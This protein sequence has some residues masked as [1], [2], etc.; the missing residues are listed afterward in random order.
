MDK[1][2]ELLQ[3]MEAAY[4]AA[5]GHAAGDV[6]DTDLRLRVLA[7]ELYRL[8]AKLEW[9]EREAFP[10]TAAGE[11]LDLHGEQRGIA[12]NPARHAVGTITFTRYLPLNADLVIPA[13]TLCATSG[14]NPVE[15]ETTEEGVL[16]KGEL[17][18][19]V[20]ARAVTGGPAGNCAAGY[21]NTITSALEGINYCTNKVPFTGGKNAEED[22]DYRRRIL[23]A[24]KHPENGVNTAYYE[25]TALRHAGVTSA[26]AVA[27]E[28]GKDTVGLYVWGED[29]AP[30]KTLLARIAA[31]FEARRE[32]GITVDVKA[33]TTYPLDPIIYFTLP[34][35]VD[36]EHAKES[37]EAAIRALF[38]GKQVG[39]ALLLAEISRAVLNAAPVLKIQIS[40]MQRDAAAVAGAIPYLNSLTV[41]AL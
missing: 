40:G 11:Q 33:A 2:E 1:F 9:V 6:S 24:Y 27:A 30:D 14:E 39:D 36:M 29:A 19:A 25:A 5:S 4:E 34:E 10:Q 35:G 20:P 26:Q 37:V 22:E 15:Y 23:N 21:I 38:A 18:V 13:G 12:R 8:W 17:N 28:N 3:G 41:E 32:M 16:P 7:G 31:D